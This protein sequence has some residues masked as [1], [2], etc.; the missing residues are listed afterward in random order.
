MNFRREFSFF[1]LA[2][3]F[4][5]KLNN[6]QILIVPILKI[7]NALQF[8]NIFLESIQYDHLKNS[9]ILSYHF[10]LCVFNSYKVQ[11]AWITSSLDIKF[12]CSPQLI[13]CKAKSQNWHAVTV[14]F[15]NILD[16]TFPRTV[17]LN[18]VPV[19]ICIIKIIALERREGGGGLPVID[20]KHCHSG[21]LQIFGGE[22]TSSGDRGCPMC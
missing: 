16:V 21:V 6:Y 17:G 18:V 7:R 8:K 13:T 3:L 20:V 22:P 10:L 12:N 9:F 2:C 15:I 14:I 11:E 1:V 19:G 5:E 4:F